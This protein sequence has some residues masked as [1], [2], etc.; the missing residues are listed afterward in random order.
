MR[1]VVPSCSIVSHPDLSKTSRVI[2]VLAH[3]CFLRSVDK[4]GNGV[5]GF[6]VVIVEGT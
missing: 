1:V 2:K 6:E 3:S 4:K 5:V